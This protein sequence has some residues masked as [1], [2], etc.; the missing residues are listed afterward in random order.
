[1]VDTQRNW[2]K[3]RNG[4]CHLEAF[5]AEEGSNPYTVTTNLCIY[6]MDTELTAVLK[7]LPY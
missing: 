1:M 7:L 5:A 2:L 3:C 6:R 4:Q